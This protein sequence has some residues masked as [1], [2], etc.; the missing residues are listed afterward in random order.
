MSKRKHYP[1]YETSSNS[2]HKHPISE[3]ES[4]H[5]TPKVL[6]DDSGLIF[7]YLDLREAEL[8]YEEI[9]VERTYA[10]H[11]IVIPSSGVIIDGGANIGLFT[12][13]CL[14]ERARQMIGPSLG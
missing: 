1:E 7:E 3:S 11:G 2:N 14:Q 13:W 6:E 10:R 12:L 9:F 4:I 5:V 8:L